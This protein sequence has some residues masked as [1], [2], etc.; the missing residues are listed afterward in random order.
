MSNVVVPF[1]SRESDSAASPACVK[2][3]AEWWFDP[4]RFSTAIEICGRCSMRA[5]CLDQALRTGE[6]LGVW[7]GLTPERRAALPDAVVI[8]FRARAGGR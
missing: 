7:G 6:R 1:P 8:P 3:P 2:H 4:A 5:T